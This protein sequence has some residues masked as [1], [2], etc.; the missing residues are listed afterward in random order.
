VLFVDDR[1]EARALA[2]AL[3][4][5]YGATIVSVESAEQALS[6]L[7]ALLPDVLISDIGMP[8]QDGYAL[9]RNVRRLP[10]SA[11]G[12]VPAIALTAYAR[13]EDALR[14]KEEGFHVHLPKPVDP[15]ELVELVANLIAGGSSG[16]GRPRGSGVFSPTQSNPNRAGSAE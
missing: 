6:A 16:G 2:D 8:G 12:N 7:K 1:A 10:L 5:R 9:I 3:F 11:G 13:A 15:D 4:E 14:A